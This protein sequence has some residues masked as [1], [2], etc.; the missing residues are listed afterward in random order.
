MAK[1]G[2]APFNIIIVVS[3]SVGFY[4][5]TSNIEYIFACFLSRPWAWWYSL[6]SN[7]V[8]HT[9]LTEGR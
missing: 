6:I 5:Y 2:R 1:H 9:V 4:T 7:A 3:R 8:V